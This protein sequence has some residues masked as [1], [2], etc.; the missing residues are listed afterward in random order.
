MRLHHLCC[1]F[2]TLFRA[3]L[4]L[5]GAVL[6]STTAAQESNRDP[7]L[8]YT[9]VATDRLRVSV[10]QEP[11]LS[12]IARVDAKGTIN[13]PLT[14]EVLVA[15]LTIAEAQKKVE[16]TYRA[17][18]FLRSPQVTINVEEYAPRTISVQG[19]VRNPGQLTLPIESG[20]T[21]LDAITKSGGFTDIAR[22]NAV[23][24]TRRQ[25]DGTTKVIPVDVQSYIRGDRRAKAED[26]LL[27]LLPGDVVYVPQRI[28]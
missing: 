13:L 16:E 23:T 9:I 12:V 7:S 2:R 1:D 21:I 6:H 8:T 10:F 27:L 20:M 24:V 25:P 22:G 3:L 18:R 15:G 26:T 19:E 5:I 4:F 11:D 28:I 17:G 14:G